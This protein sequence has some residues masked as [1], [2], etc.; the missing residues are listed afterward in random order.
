MPNTRVMVLWAVLM[1]AVAAEAAPNPATTQV[2]L[3]RMQDQLK[4]EILVKYHISRKVLRED[5]ALS[6][7][8]LPGPGKGRPCLSWRTELA[9]KGERTYGVTTTADRKIPNRKAP[10]TIVKIFDGLRGWSLTGGLPDARML[11]GNMLAAHWRVLV[12][13]EEIYLEVNGLES[14]R[15]GWGITFRGGETDTFSVA[16]AFGKGEYSIAPA[17]SQVDGKKCILL[18]RPGLDKVWIDPSRGY[19][20]LKREWNW[21]KGK[22]LKVRITNSE[23]REESK[24]LWLPYHSLVEYCSK[25]DATPGL[26]CMTTDLVVDEL[27]TSVPDSIFVPEIAVGATVWDYEN[28]TSWSM[29]PREGKSFEKI[30]EESRF[31]LRRSPIRTAVPPNRPSAPTI[32]AIVVVNLLVVVGLAVYLLRRRR[33]RPQ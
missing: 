6:E 17:P 1:M 18:E 14:A 21:A 25:S 5:P 23:L 27:S 7:A 20:L 33:R 12:P 32:V 22:P 29:P 16:D 2:G 30:I 9:R 24:G 4:K 13:E 19:A 28:N 31:H 10:N 8:H 15:Q 26:V 3:R 11:R